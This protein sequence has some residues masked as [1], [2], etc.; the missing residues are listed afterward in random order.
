[1]DKLLLLQLSSH[2]TQLQALLVQQE[3]LD[4]LVLSGPLEILVHL[5]YVDHQDVSLSDDDH[6]PYPEEG[7]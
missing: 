7:R 6:F 3:Q 5:D 1:M 4:L 2:Q